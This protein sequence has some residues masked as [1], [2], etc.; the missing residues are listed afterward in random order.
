LPEKSSSA[1]QNLISFPDLCQIPSRNNISHTARRLDALYHHFG[2]QSPFP[3]NK[4]LATFLDLLIFTNV[5]DYKTILGIDQRHS[6]LQT[7]WQS[8]FT[9]QAGFKILQALFGSERQKGPVKF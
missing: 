1:D 5:Q 4:Q 2:D 7:F 8:N 3:V 6:T 9:R